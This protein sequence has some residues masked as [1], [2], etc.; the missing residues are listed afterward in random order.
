VAA[1]ASIGRKNIRSAIDVQCG[2]WQRPPR[3]FGRNIPKES[4]VFSRVWA[5]LGGRDIPPGGDEAVAMKLIVG[6]GNPGEKYKGT[7]HNVGFDVV[8]RLSVQFTAPPPRAKFQGAV[9]EVTIG[10]ERVLLLTPHTY[11]NASGTSVLAAR[12]FYKITNEDIL[13][14]CDDFALP[15]GKLRLRAKGSSGGQKGLEDIIRRLGADEISRL[16]LGIGIPPAGRDAAGFVL[17]RF[18]KD[19]Q[20]LATEMIERATEAAAAWVQ[21]GIATAMNRFNAGSGEG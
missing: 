14:V 3:T 15:L 8:E 4:A 6:L 12:D 16:R 21:S 17:S 19:E 9:T 7:R 5:W 10:G 1:A 20:S 18:M 11:M 2:R 13:V